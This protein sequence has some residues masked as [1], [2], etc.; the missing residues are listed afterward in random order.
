MQKTDPAPFVGAMSEP[1]PVTFGQA[2]R[3]RVPELLMLIATG[4]VVLLLIALPRSGDL[5]RQI[6]DALYEWLMKL[7]G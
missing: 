7:N 3:E 2:L 1:E 4:I 5:F 6:R